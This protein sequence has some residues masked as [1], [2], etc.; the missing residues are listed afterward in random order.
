SARLVSWLRSTA[1]PGVDWTATSLPPG[2][3]RRPPPYSSCLFLLAVGLLLGEVL[4]VFEVLFVLVGLG[5]VLLVLEVPFVEVLLV[6]EVP[7]VEVLLVIEVLDVGALRSLVA[8]ADE[9][10]DELGIQEAPD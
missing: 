9:V 7:F 5:E 8:A 4:F 2:A 3:G 1:L 6:L 10:A